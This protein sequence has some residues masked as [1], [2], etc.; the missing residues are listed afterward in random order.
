[1]SNQWPARCWL[2]PYLEA[3][4][5]LAQVVWAATA[6]ELNNVPTA[7]RDRMRVLHS[8]SP[9]VSTYQRW[10]KGFWPISSVSV[11]WK[12]DGPYPWMEMNDVDWMSHGGVARCAD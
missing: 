1:V 5:N 8:K 12:R 7:L 4:V 11:G 10:R 6:N 9:S 2:D 3:P